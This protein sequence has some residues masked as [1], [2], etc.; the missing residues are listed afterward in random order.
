MNKTVTWWIV[1][2][3]AVAL[4]AACGPQE[5]EQ[6]PDEVSVRLKWLHNT[7]SAGFYVADEKGFYAEENIAVTL[8]PGGP[9]VDELALVASGQDMF[10]VIG[11][12]QLIMRQSEVQSIVA[13]AAI[14]R[15]NPAVYFALKETGI[16]E[17]KD[18]TGRRV[19]VYPGDFMLPAMLARSGVGIEQ[20]EAVEPGTTASLDALYSGEVE[21]WT[22]YLTNEVITAEG[23]GY[24]LNIIYPDDYGV[25]AYGDVVIAS[26]R[27]TEENPDLVERFLR[28]TLRGWHYAVEN[29]EEATAATLK[30]DNSLD[31]AHEMAAMEA[32]VPLIHTGEDQIGWMRAEVWEGMQQML[33]EQ[34][35]MAEPVDLDTV[36]TMEF[37]ERVYGEQP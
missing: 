10:G 13:I 16:D 3:L 15:K 23:Q 14:F 22:G 7:Q 37:L 36:Y 8:L 27:L 12:D 26:T 33:L 32:S 21:V 30:Y 18:F 17:P 28:A 9:D 11:A 1:L 5:I 6:P 25:H 4:L 19:L 24:E 29:P 35:L 34:G 2:G 31:E 20:I